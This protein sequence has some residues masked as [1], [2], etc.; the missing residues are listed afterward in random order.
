MKERNVAVHSCEHVHAEIS[1]KV[2]GV[3]GGEARVPVT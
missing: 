1:L 2:V 3:G